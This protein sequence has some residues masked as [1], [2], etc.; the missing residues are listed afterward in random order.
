MINIELEYHLDELYVNC[1]FSGDNIPDDVSNF[2]SKIGQVS[3]E[4]I[5]YFN[6]QFYIR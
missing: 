1:Q 4:V 2:I 6:E 5:F 3:L